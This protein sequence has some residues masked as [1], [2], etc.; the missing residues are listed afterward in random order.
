MG[1]A[2]VAAMLGMA[3]FLMGHITRFGRTWLMQSAQITL[4]RHEKRL[5]DEN[6][7]NGALNDRLIVVETKTNPE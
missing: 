1:G 5:Y 7:G 6:I 4:N 2:A 3:L